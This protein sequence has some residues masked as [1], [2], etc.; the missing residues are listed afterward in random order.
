MMLGKPR[1][2]RKIWKALDWGSASPE[3]AANLERTDFSIRI[4]TYV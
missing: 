2:G 1:G 4:E 3:I